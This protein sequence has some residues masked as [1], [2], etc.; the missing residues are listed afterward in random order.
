[1]YNNGVIEEVDDFNYIGT[2]FHKA[3][4]FANNNEKLSVNQ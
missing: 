3:S 2:V 1:M 4:T